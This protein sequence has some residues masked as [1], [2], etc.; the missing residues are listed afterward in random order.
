MKSDKPLYGMTT[1][2][3]ES[4][5]SDSAAALLEKRGAT[6][7]RSPSMQEVPLKDHHEI[8]RFAEQLFGGGVDILICMTGVGTQILID[9]LETRYKRSEIL[10]RLRNL[11]IVVRGP[12]PVRIL[13]KMDVP[14][15]VAAPEPNTWIELLDAIDEH[16]TT[17]NLAGKKVAVQEYGETNQGFLEALDQRGA[18]IIRIPVYRWALPDDPAPLWKGIQA[19]LNGQVQIALFTSKTQIEHVMQVA[20]KK[21]VGQALQ[22]ALNKTFIASIG[23]VC[24]NGLH[25]HG[26]Q[27]DFEPTRSK[28][29]VFIKELSEFAPAVIRNTGRI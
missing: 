10:K 20:N 24:T 1:V 5:L 11:T 15:E 6:V 4:R 22:Q 8:F 21:R 7:I 3:F 9:T 2:C 17:A 16:E 29:G 19:V 27:V 23:P 13:K 25:G 12:K 18:E 14:F 26:L 28:L